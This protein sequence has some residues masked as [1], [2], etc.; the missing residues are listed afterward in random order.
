M[1]S[2]VWFVAGAAAGVYGMV[3]ARRV[4]ETFTAEGLSDR[5][6]ALRLGAQ[7]FRQEVA[8]GRT[9]AEVE[10]RERLQSLAA[11]GGPK[12]LEPSNSN[13]EGL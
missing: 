8:Q 12:E 1:K 13:E 2:G 4:A 6:N 7:L 3:K 9:D 10:L 5:A 11:G